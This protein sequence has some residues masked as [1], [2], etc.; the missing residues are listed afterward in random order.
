M[1]AAATPLE[2]FFSYSHADAQLRD[3]LERHLAVL[4]RSGIIVAWY[5]RQI[6]AGVEWAGQIDKHLARAGI[7]RL[8][9]S[10]DFLASDYCKATLQMRPV[11]PTTIGIMV[12]E[13]L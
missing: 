11:V 4:K 2:P 6:G 1:A 7:M 5:D 10:A 9:I 3:E 12:T 8:L 13:I